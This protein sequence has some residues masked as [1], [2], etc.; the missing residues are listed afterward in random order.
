MKTT[1][2]FFILFV[3]KGI[4]LSYV[5][6]RIERRKRQDALRDRVRSARRYF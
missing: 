6:T 4:V 5:E 2:F 1:L 3:L